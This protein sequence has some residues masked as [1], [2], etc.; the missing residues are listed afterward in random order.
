[1]QNFPSKPQ[2]ETFQ[3][4]SLWTTMWISFRS[5]RKLCFGKSRPLLLSLLASSAVPRFFFPIKD[6]GP[7]MQLSRGFCHFRISYFWDCGIYCP[8]VFSKP[9]VVS[10]WTNFVTFM[11]IQLDEIRCSLRDEENCGTLTHWVSVHLTAPETSSK[12]L[13][14]S[15]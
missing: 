14:V 13:Y 6:I 3:C 7:I 5:S 1:M 2:N 9:T 8:L 11:S 4:P 12:T 10:F 15:I